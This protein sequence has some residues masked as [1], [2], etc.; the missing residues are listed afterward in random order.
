MQRERGLGE[1][2]LV[3]TRAWWLRGRWLRGAH[4]G[5]AE[6]SA[7]AECG[8][9]VR[10]RSAGAECGIGRG[11][12]IAASEGAHLRDDEVRVAVDAAHLLVR[13]EAP[14][15]GDDPAGSFEHA[16]PR[17]RGKYVACSRVWPQ[18]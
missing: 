9:G 14:D 5:G 4:G 10:E 13:P 17:L 11:S 2:G 15:A 6:R 16:A 3:E 8:S 18:K 1:M 7:G 12:R